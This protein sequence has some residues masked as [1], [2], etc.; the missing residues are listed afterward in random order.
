[1][2]PNVLRKLLSD[3]VA[4]YVCDLLFFSSSSPRAL[5][6]HLKSRILTENSSGDTLL[7]SLKNRND[8]TS[9]TTLS[10]E[11]SNFEIQS[12][13][14]QIWIFKVFAS[15]NLILAFSGSDIC[16]WHSLL[17]FAS[18][19]RSWHSLHTKM[20][21]PESWQQSG[22]KPSETFHRKTVR[23]LLVCKFLLLLFMHQLWCTQVVQLIL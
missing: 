3:Y 13:R 22:E 10:I 11:V 17:A 19:I 6:R 2:T 4:D 20:G 14:F 9:F 12:C 18:D 7:K 1:M 5:V 23:K 21:T 16:F 15:M 8:S